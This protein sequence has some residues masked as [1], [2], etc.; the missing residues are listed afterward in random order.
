[1]S[2]IV[3]ASPLVAQTKFGVFTRNYNNQRS[4]A[5]TSEKVLNTSN[6]NARQFGKVFQLPVDDQ[7]YAGLLYAPDVLVRGRKHNLVYV[8]TVNNTVYAFDADAPGPPLWYRNFNGT[9][10]PTDHREVGQACRNYNDFIGNIGIVGTPVIAPGGTMYFVTRTVEGGN[11]FQRLH[12]VDIATGRERAGSPQVIRATVPGIGDDAIGSTVSF[13]SVTNNQRSALAYADGVVYIAWASFCDTRPYHG[14]MMSYD[15]ATLRP[16]GVFNTTPNN[17]ESGIWMS[18][19]GPAFDSAGNLYVTT[20]NGSYDGATEFGEALI[21]LQKRTLHP[22]DFFAPSNF[23]TL[24][25]FDLDF[26]TQ[27]VTVLPGTNLL[28]T[29]GKEGKVYLVDSSAMGGSAAGDLQLPQVMQAIDGSVRPRQ[30]HH[31]HNSIPAWRGPDGVNIYAWGENDFLRAYRFDPA[32]KKFKHPAFASADVLPPMGMPAGMMAISADGSKHGTGIV[33]AT[34]PRVGDANQM[35]VPGNLYA[36]DAETLKLLWSSNGPG[37]DILSFAKGSPP[38]VANGK[39]YV[40]SISNIVS[41]FGLRDHEPPSQDMALNAKASGTAPCEPPQTPDKA[42]NGS[43]QS[44]PADKWC[45]SA[46]K[47]WLQIDLGKSVEVGRFVIEH[48]GAGGDDLLMNT[49]EFNIQLSDDGEHF[50]QVVDV[51]NNIQSITT[52]DIHPATARYVRLNIVQPTQTPG[53]ATANVYEFEVFPPV[54][55]AKPEVPQPAKAAASL[56]VADPPVK[57]PPAPSDVAAPAAG[58]EF[59]ASRVAMTVLQ[60]GSGEG[61]PAANDCVRAR[62]NVWERNGALF[63][64]SLGESEIVCVRTAMI[65]V[66]EALERMVTGEKR[67]VWI[68]ADLTYREGQHARM[69]SRPQEMEAPPHNDLT[70]DIE[71][72][73]LLKAPPTP[74]HLAAPPE[75]AVRTASGLTYE[76]LA[77]G[78]GAAHPAPN[79]TVRVQFTGWTNDGHLFESTVMSGHAALV[80]LSQAMPGWREGLTRMTVGEKA[81]FWIPAALAWGARPADRFNP[82]GDLIYEIELLDVQ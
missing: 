21:K 19:A 40:A 36:F 52:H 78:H 74:T 25:E 81:R 66:A 47:P 42:V 43:T 51:W 17:R 56:A 8:A 13:N 38:I 69:M 82:A 12:A 24:N 70:V 23:N 59:T 14:W 37:D 32:G 54:V 29:G 6:V 77:P 22:L 46:E 2:A 57:A 3:L 55:P 49:R 30:S 11:T 58:A 33:W 76:V 67:R 48:A 34:A 28:V 75:H 72:I 71:L 10:R 31:L 68:P 45:S 64:S 62:F 50:R 60:P 7:V 1:V 18:G 39:V 73:S 4:G 26:G 5:N 53:E 35:T 65:G 20:G 9:G 15:A 79:S 80:P 63:A 41:V 44:G 16:V 61:H 27:G